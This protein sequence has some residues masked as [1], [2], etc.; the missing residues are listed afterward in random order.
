V[1][2]SP[3]VVIAADTH[4]DSHHLVDSHHLAVITDAGKPL[5]DT[6]FPTSQT[7]YDDSVRWAQSFGTIVIAGVEGADDFLDAVSGTLGLAGSV[8]TVITLKRS[9]THGTGVLSVTGRDV[10]ENVYSLAFADGVWK[11]DGSDLAEAANRV[12]ERKLGAKMRAALE[13][14]NSRVQTTAADVVDA[15]S[16]DAEDASMI[17][18]GEA[19]NSVNC[20]KEELVLSG[21]EQ[22]RVTL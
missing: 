5:A 4:L 9:R 11:V 1:T 22:H 17:D 7:G 14:V 10:E 2:A 3:R 15:D 20:S 16:A 6:E 12:T 8:D 18:V 19:E 21:V 13:L